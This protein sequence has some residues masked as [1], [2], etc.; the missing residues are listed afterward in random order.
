[1]IKSFFLTFPEFVYFTNFKKTTGEVVW[2]EQMTL[3]HPDLK[4]YKHLM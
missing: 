3:P 1:M 2:I 4:Q